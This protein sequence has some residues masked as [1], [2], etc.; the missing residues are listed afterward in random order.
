MDTIEVL[1]K[2]RTSTAVASGSR[3]SE[4]VWNGCQGDTVAVTSDPRTQR[5]GDILGSAVRRYSDR[6]PASVNAR[7]RRGDLLAAV[8]LRLQGR[9]RDRPVSRS[10]PFGS[11]AIQPA[12]HIPTGIFSDSTLGQTLLARQSQDVFS[13]REAA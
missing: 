1:D 9:L 4:L 7:G 8:A 5:H 2:T 10:T 12:P 3:R 13:L 11:L 6:H